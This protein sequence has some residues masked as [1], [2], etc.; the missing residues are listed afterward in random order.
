MIKDRKGMV[1]ISWAPFCSRS[2]SIAA[3]LDGQSYMVYSPAYGSHFVTVP[4]K[5]LS[6][7]VK[8]L[9]ILFRERPAFVFV[10]TPPIFACL[11]AWL[12]CALTGASFVIDAHTGAF[13][14]SRSKPLLFIHKW[15]SRSARMTIVTNEY[16]YDIVRAWNAAATIVR[17]VPVCFATPSHPKLGG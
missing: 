11:P 12:Y 1:F 7:T 9:R 3:R 14:D 6:Q 17:D 15:F 2:D 10:M 4:F 16:M 13:L 5:Y 8:T